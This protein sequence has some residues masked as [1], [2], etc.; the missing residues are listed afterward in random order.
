MTSQVLPIDALMNKVGTL[1]E[2]ELHEMLHEY[3]INYNEYKNTH[4]HIMKLPQFKNLK[5]HTRTKESHKSIIR[6]LSNQI[7]E[8]TDEIIMLKE[9]LDSYQNEP[10]CDQE[11]ISL[12]ITEP[13]MKIVADT[14]TKVYNTLLEK[15][16]ETEKK[17][18]EEEE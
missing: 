4:T 12:K 3:M 8:M 7:C 17:E 15:D 18:T 10:R 2:H 13:T 5:H 9:K 1:L 16:A 11:H 14:E 6:M